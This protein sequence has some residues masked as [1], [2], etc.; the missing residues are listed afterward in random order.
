MAAVCRLTSQDQ[1]SKVIPDACG[2]VWAFIRAMNISHLGINV[3]VYLDLAM[4]LECG[5]LVAQHFGPSGNVI[6]TA[7]PGGQVATTIHLGPYNRLG[8]AHDAI[9]NWCRAQA[10]VIAGPFWEVYDHW[11]DDPAKLRTDVFYLLK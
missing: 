9:Q 10:L 5:V 7:T 2:E 11:N 4:N 6:C 1:L 3:C 8:E